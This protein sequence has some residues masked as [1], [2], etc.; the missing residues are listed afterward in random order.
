MTQ[1]FVVT[2]TVTATILAVFCFIM[3]KHFVQLYN[4]TYNIALISRAHTVIN[5][6]KFESSCL[7]N[8]KYFKKCICMMISWL[9]WHA[10]SRGNFHSNITWMTSSVFD[11]FCHSFQ[12]CLVMWPDLM[13]ESRIWI[14]PIVMDG[15]DGLNFLLSLHHEASLS[16]CY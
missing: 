10:N 7:Q 6:L 5:S 14:L 4:V 3:W 15:G 16:L 9:L 13:L 2:F 12:I 11:N 8:W 1:Q